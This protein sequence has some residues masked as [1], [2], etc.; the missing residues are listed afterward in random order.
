MT[1]KAQKQLRVLI[2]EDEPVLLMELED[3]LADLGYGVCWARV[4]PV[5]KS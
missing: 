4:R 2:V 3:A 1:A 5:I